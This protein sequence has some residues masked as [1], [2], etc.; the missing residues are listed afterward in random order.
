MT[1]HKL[2]SIEYRLK[3]IDI[4]R[5]FKVIN[6][7]EYCKRWMKLVVELGDLVTEPTRL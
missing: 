3:T 2:S 5:K 1:D 6:E 7:D 4:L